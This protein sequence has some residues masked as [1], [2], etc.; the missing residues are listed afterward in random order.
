MLPEW[1]RYTFCGVLSYIFAIRNPYKNDIRDHIRH[2]AYPPIY[3][4][5]PQRTLF[6]QFVMVIYD[7]LPYHNLSNMATYGLVPY[8]IAQ[9]AQFYIYISLYIGVCPQRAIFAQF[10][11]AIHDMLT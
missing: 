9:Y 3:G 1:P 2:W 8:Y 6:A 7:I 10:M 4:A 11:I 5:C